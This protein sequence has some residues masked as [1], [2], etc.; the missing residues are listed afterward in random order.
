VYVTYGAHTNDFLLVEYGFIL[1]ENY[2]D[3]ESLDHL[4]LPKLS[5]EQAEILKEDGFY[6]YATSPIHLRKPPHQ[7]TNAQLF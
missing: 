4:I 5:K 7:E 3:D 2:N 1:R 6:G